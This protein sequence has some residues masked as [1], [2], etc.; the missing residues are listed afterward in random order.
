MNLRLDGKNALVCGASKGLGLATAQ[1]LAEMGAKVTIA[2]S[3]EENLKKAIQTLDK[4][5][6]HDYVA[7]DFNDYEAVRR[8][9]SLKMDNGVRYDILVNNS[10]G[11]PPG[12]V[13]DAKIEDFLKAIQRHLFSSH[14]LVQLLVPFMKEKGFGRIINIISISVKEPVQNL[15]VSNTVR[16][17]MNSWSKTL[18]KELAEYGITVNNVLPGHTATERMEN[19]I[20]A[21]AERSGMTE[22]EIKEKTISKIPVGRMG[23]PE[24]LANVAGFLAS[25]EAEFITGWNI[26]VDGGF[27]KGY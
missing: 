27:L 18:S 7:V 26:P 25:K 9:F 16:G 11:P 1:R 10:G 5:E 21:N 2:S 20:K 12:T 3:N 6:M 22:Q 17:A 19:L 13:L 4:P 8:E 14:L 24:D 15:G 23:E